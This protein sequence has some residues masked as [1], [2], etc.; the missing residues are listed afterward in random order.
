MSVES[1]FLQ[2]AV[3]K[4]R[5]FACRI[6]VCLEKLEEDQLWARGQENENAVGNLVLHLT[7]NVRQWILSSLGNNPDQRD[8]DGEFNARGGFTAAV[9]ATN[10]RGTV[11]R[12][13]LIISELTTAQLTA[14]YQ[15][16]NYTV[17]GVQVVFH[18]VEHFAQHTGQIIFAT[19]M[20]SGEDL[21]F[22]RHLRNAVHEE[23]VP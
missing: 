21:G 12:A 7:G 19:K 23:R 8:R 6:E 10:M 4:L 20:L 9:L 3:E 2:C 11:E 15:I 5:Q 22:Y 1:L 14:T 13:A 16:Q 18:V 17:S